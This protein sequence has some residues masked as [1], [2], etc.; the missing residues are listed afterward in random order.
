MSKQIFAALEISDGDIRLIIGEFFN[1]RFNVIRVEN[2]KT[3]GIKNSIIVNPALVTLDIRNT[4]NNASKSLGVEIEKVIMCVPSKD[5][6]RHLLKVKVKVDNPEGYITLEEIRKGIKL[7]INTNVEN[8]S[9]LLVNAV[10]T[11]YYCNGIATRK[12]PLYERCNDFLVD[13]DLFYSDSNTIME[14]INIVEAAGLGILD[15]FLE[16]YAA[17]KEMVL[18]EQSLN[19]NI[20]MIKLER[21][22]TTLSIISKGHLAS[23]K[24]LSSGVEN[25]YRKILNEYSLSEETIT[26]LITYNVKLSAKTHDN[27]PIHV[28][29]DKGETK[30]I[31]EREIF[32]QI[33]NPIE[34]W[35][36]EIKDVCEPILEE[37]NLEI[38]LI[39]EGAEVTN[40]ADVL[41]NMIG[42]NVKTY[43]PETLGARNS[44]YASTLGALYAY[45]EMC[46]IKI[47]NE[48]SVDM[49]KY[50]EV[51]KSTKA[52]DVEQTITSS[53]KNLLTRRK[54]T[55]N[56]SIDV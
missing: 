7:A 38:V 43:V 41:E 32:N 55:S 29:E 6:I 42:K 19:N 34:S 44:K 17:C 26:K 54:E 5:V 2:I 36:N 22:S 48:T 23:V 39:G 16:T 11:K 31:S 8:T 49:L 47:D 13:V 9:R 4:I 27:T 33:K 56:E 21:A 52:E 3:E 25:W 50:V 46:D 51:L 10:P 35:I 18:L 15:I 37:E 24:W 12:M 1:I 20:L 30:T 45:K 53:F 40:I 28:W 14:L